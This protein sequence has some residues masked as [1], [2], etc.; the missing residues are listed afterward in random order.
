MS[1]ASTYITSSDFKRDLKLPLDNADLVD[2]NDYIETVSDK[3]M[4]RLLGESL[5]SEFETAMDGTPAQKWLDLFDGVVYTNYVDNS[6]V[7]FEGCKQMLL[8]FIYFEVKESTTF[9][10]MNGDYSD[11]I[12][13]SE[14][15]SAVISNR[16]N[17]EKFNKGQV[18]YYNAFNFMKQSLDSGS[19]DY[20]GLTFQG[21][22][23]Q[24]INY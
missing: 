19:D 11:T 9:A 2:F 1:W 17:S 16:S 22:Q 20:D 15:V 8:Y 7:H 21:L 18:I 5:Y 24:H 3:Y 23:R 14:K 13:N 10:A 6:E 12:S 4:R